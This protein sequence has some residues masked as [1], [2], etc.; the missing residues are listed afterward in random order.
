[1][2]N[3]VLSCGVCCALC[4]MC[5]QY[6]WVFRVCNTYTCSQ[7]K[8]QKDVKWATHNVN[9]ASTRSTIR[10][11]KEVTC[12][13]VVAADNVDIVALVFQSLFDLKCTFSHG[14]FLLHF[15]L[16]VASWILLAQ[17]FPSFSRL[18]I[19]PKGLGK[20]CWEKSLLGCWGHLVVAGVSLANTSAQDQGRYFL[21]SSTLKEAQLAQIHGETQMNRLFNRRVRVLPTSDW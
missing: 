3:C 12:K 20:D 1:M 4:D 17:L 15:E 19:P 6:L 7:K 14:L 16:P 2:H 21:D 18:L 13:S 11:S 5:V 10:T 9:F 8:S